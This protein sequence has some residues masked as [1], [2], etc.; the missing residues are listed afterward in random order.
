MQPNQQSQ[1]PSQNEWS[2]RGY[3]P[4][5]P[6]NTPY[7]PQQMT[8]QQQQQYQE[9]Q[10]T[11]ME[12]EKLR[13]QPQR[14]PEIMQRAE[15]LQQ[16]MGYIKAQLQQGSQPMMP[17]QQPPQQRQH[18]PQMPQYPQQQQMHAQ[19]GPGPGPG[20]MMN[21]TG[22]PQNNAG[23]PAQSQMPPGNM[24][25]SMQGASRETA[26]SA[27]SSVAVMQTAPNQVQVNIFGATTQ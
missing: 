23:T 27:A 6:A 5:A 7:Y 4:S 26:P 20:P 17:P 13:A 2:Q 8:P 10:A 1:N 19:G 11:Q 18:Q 15:Q 22:Y 24:Q 21:S 9:L 16:K 14:T 3:P 12:F 25:I